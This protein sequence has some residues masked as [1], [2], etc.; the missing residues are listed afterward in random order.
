MVED[1]SGIRGDAQIT[2]VSKDDGRTMS[3]QHY[4]NLVVNNGKNF[5]A[6]RLTNQA[7]TYDTC[8]FYNIM[9][10]RRNAAV[11]V[12]DTLATYTTSQ[13]TSTMICSNY[14][15]NSDT[16]VVSSASF[17]GNELNDNATGKNADTVWNSICLL[18]RAA[19]PVLFSAV[20]VSDPSA[21]TTNDYLI[22]RW[23]V[24]YS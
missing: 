14:L 12:T 11:V 19:V 18:T 9:L 13:T 10:S 8:S 20:S 15:T 16:Q 24:S 2:I 5:L 3:E 17:D 7:T 21:W 4:R 1:S 23:T 22:V 6:N